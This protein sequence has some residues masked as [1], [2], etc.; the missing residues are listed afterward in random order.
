M[1]LCRTIGTLIGGSLSGR[2]L[3]AECEAC[4]GHDG[5]L[6][7]DWSGVQGVILA[8]SQDDPKPSCGPVNAIAL[9]F[10]NLLGIGLGAAGI[11]T[12]TE[13]GF[14]DQNALRYSI[15]LTGAG[16]LPII[17]ARLVAA[18]THCRV[19]VEKLAAQ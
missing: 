8:A 16:I 18:L 5:N 6:H 14:N 9:L 3:H 15:A 7:I 17:V 10:V 11:P 12:I 19:E 1:R 13:F 2:L 4:A